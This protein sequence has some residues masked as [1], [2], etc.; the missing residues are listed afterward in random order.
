MYKVH[1]PDELRQLN[2]LQNK[3]NILVRFMMNGC[4]GC[5]HSQSDWDNACKRAKLSPDDAILELESNFV[6]Q[7]KQ[8]MR[9]RNA[10]IEIYKFPT[11][12]LIRGSRV[13]E[14]PNRDTASILNMLKS[15]KTR[16]VRRRKTKRTYLNRFF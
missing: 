15:I 10:N 4:P 12:M 6:D 9:A 7:F 3:K 16:R 2:Y 14:L 5:I 13:T 11:I 1:T 8:S